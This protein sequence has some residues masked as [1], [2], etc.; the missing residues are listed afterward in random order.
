VGVHLIIVVGIVVG[1]HDADRV[2]AE[3]G[4]VFGQFDR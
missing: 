4:G 2:D 1:R 3:A